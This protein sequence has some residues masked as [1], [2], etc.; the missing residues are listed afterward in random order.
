[1]VLLPVDAEGYLEHNL[2]EAR[3][4]AQVEVGGTSLLLLKPTNKAAD[5][6]K[7]GMLVEEGSPA[8]AALT[9]FVARSLGTFTCE[10]PGEGEEAAACDQG[11]RRRAPR[12]PPRATANINRSL[13]AILRRPFTEFGRHLRVRT[14]VVHGYSNNA[15]RPQGLPP[16]RRP[17]PRGRRGR[18]RRPSPPTSPRFLGCDPASVGE[19]ECAAAFIKDF[20]R[21]A[22]RR[23][24]SAAEAAA[25]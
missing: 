2:A 3:E 23:P 11:R 24:L 17:V 22:Y 18:R 15:E 20:G 4:L 12:P 1:L 7:G 13:D 8:H 16:A 9:E 21:R 19:P 14:T 6:H 5:G 25:L 10:G